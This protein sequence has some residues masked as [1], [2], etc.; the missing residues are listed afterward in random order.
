MIGRLNITAITLLFGCA[1][2]KKENPEQSQL[3]Q[4]SIV[5]NCNV[6]CPECGFTKAETMPTDACL[7]KYT[8][9]NCKRTLTAKEGDCCVFC[10][11]SDKICPPEQ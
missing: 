3:P 9:T 1:E 11:Y 2:M 8:C 10:S 6:T 5:T 7:G 4:D